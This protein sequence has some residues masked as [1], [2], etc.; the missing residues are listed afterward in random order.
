MFFYRLRLVMFHPQPNIFIDEHIPSDQAGV[1]SNP[2]QATSGPPGALNMG[3]NR[4]VTSI[5]S[6]HGD[7][8]G[9]I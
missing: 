1:D 9:I 3:V 5:Y 7:T 8:E 2:W 6:H 4:T